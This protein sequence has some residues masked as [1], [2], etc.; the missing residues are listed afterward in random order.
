MRCRTAEG[1]SELCVKRDALWGNGARSEESLLPLPALRG[2]VKKRGSRR[3]RQF[4]LQQRG[5]GGE[6]AA[7]VDG[8]AEAAQGLEMLGHGVTLVALKTVDPMG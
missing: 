3:E 1:D 2:E 5:D 6:Q 4:S 7:V 8:G